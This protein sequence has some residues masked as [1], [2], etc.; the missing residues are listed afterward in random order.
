MQSTINHKQFQRRTRNQ[1]PNFPYLEKANSWVFG[2]EQEPQQLLEP[3]SQVS[4]TMAKPNVNLKNVGTLAEVK[5]TVAQG[6][7]KAFFENSKG[8]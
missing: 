6:K 5:T 8:L 2:H 1:N 7:D 3:D 4:R